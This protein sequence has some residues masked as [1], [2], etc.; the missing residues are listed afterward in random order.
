MLGQE[1]SLLA[2]NLWMVH[3]MVLKSHVTQLIERLDLLQSYMLGQ[4]V[5]VYLAT[6]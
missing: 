3:K 2:D 4:V 6:F 1:G 5:K